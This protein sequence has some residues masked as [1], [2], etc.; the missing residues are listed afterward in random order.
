MD[1]DRE[2]RRF[3]GFSNDDSFLDID[4]VQMS[5]LVLKFSIWP[6]TTSFLRAPWLARYALRRQRHRVDA[7]APGPKRDLWGMPDE[8]GYFADDNSLLKG[9]FRNLRIS[10]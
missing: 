9:A 8:A 4:E 10:G 2:L 3:L 1:A 7:R 6:S 5:S